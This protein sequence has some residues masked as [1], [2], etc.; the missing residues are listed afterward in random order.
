MATAIPKA[1]KTDRLQ[2]GEFD[3]RKLPVFEILG[4]HDDRIELPDGSLAYAIDSIQGV[5]LY[6]VAL[7]MDAGDNVRRRFLANKRGLGGILAPT[8]PN[9][10]GL[11]GHRG[12]LVCIGDKQIGWLVTT[13]WIDDVRQ[14]LQGR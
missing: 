12:Q 8:R 13:S 11:S 2:T 9:G 7:A 14:N 5:G 3:T 6:R 10:G 4:D 1:K